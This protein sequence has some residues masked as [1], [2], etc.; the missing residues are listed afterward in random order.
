[1]F[2]Q[3]HAADPSTPYSQPADIKYAAIMLGMVQY[4]VDAVV[5]I[6]SVGTLHPDKIPVGSL[7]V[8]NDFYCPADLRP[9]YADARAHFVP[10]TFLMC[11]LSARL[12]SACVVFQHFMRSFARKCWM[13][14]FP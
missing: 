9:V 7:V 4:R 14:C 13:C 8:P 3:R 10:S 2:C 1:V 12:L 11:G 5:A 6:C